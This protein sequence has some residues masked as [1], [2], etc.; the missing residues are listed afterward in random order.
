MRILLVEDEAHLAA[1]VRDHL[2]ANGET[3]DWCACLAD[4]DAALRSTDYG[5]VVL[6]LHMPDG[7]GI[8]FLR[9]MRKRG[10]GTPVLIASARDQI[11]DR[12]EGLDSGADDYI[13]KPYDLDEMIARIGAIKRR[14]AGTPSPVLMLGTLAIDM[15]AK[16]VTSDG[17]DIPITRREW[18]ILE[19][20][21]RR[22]NAVLSKEQL[23][24]VLYAFGEDVNSNAVEVHISRL[25]GKLGRGTIRTLRGVGYSIPR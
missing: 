15:V 11:S 23:E 18:A 12:I 20:L 6:D 3:V 5:L 13:V 8:D 17:K 16:R 14:H 21:L 10:D 1:A 2:V 25:R 22:P 24:D 7:R 19:A 4:A 9:D